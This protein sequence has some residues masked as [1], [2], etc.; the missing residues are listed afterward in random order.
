M[1]TTVALPPLILTSVDYHIAAAESHE[2]AAE[3]HR[4]AA[5]AYMYGD[6]QQANEKARLARQ[7]GMQASEQCALAME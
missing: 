7:Y 2:E 5:A 1:Y 3:A 6:F 4:Q